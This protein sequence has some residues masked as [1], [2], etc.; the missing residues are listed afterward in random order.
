MT[1]QL[2]DRSSLQGECIELFRAA[3]KSPYTRDPYERRLINFLNQVKLTPDELVTLGKK[4][5][6][7]V[8]KIVMVFIGSTKSK[9]RKKRDNRC[10]RFQL[11]KGSKTAFGNE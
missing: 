10:Y 5:P 7:A 2:L 11:S 1:R 9:S 8:E 3:I 4:E 6:F